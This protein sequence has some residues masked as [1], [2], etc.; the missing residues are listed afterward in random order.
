MPDDFFGSM[1][2]F[3][4]NVGEGMFA[5]D[6]MLTPVGYTQ[7]VPDNF[8]GSMTNFDGNVGEGMFAHDPML[9]PVGDIPW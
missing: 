1:T 3:D 2:N 9:P 4:G 5:H 6:P 7:Q 8:F